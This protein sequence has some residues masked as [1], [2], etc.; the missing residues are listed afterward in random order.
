MTMALKT[1]WFKALLRQDVT[2]YDII[3]VNAN[4][5][6]KDVGRKLAQAVQVR[7]VLSF[8]HGGFLS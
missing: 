4:K 1:D 6:R 7:F 5:Y 2:Y 3:S 8:Q